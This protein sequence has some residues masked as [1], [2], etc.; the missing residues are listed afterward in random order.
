MKAIAEIVGCGKN[1]IK[2]DLVS[3]GI[4]IRNI[5]EQRK[6]DQEAGR[7]ATQSER[8]KQRHKD[9]CYANAMT[10]ERR[11]RLSEFAS[12]RTGEKNPF[13]GKKHSAKTKKALSDHALG[14]W[15]ESNGAITNLPLFAD[16]I[17]EEREESPTS[18]RKGC[19]QRG[20]HNSFYGRKHSL[21][22]RLKISA[23]RGG[24]G[25]EFVPERHYTTEWTHEL[26]ERI[27]RRDNYT[28]LIC[29]VVQSHRKH[30]VHHIDY[31]KNN[32]AESNLVTLCVA[33]HCK[34]A[35]NRE[36]WIAFFGKLDIGQGGGS[37]LSTHSA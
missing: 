4:R 7:A 10:P 30:S 6:I 28:C 19:G 3:L 23:A 2:R 32:C 11:K 15:S 18:L 9:G 27:R 1:T 13:F 35:R 31:D 14:R 24:D 36:A 29:Y 12:Q 21:A 25:R 8:I 5:W 33:C 16:E 22:T 34:T 26:R 17:R 20:I 37:S